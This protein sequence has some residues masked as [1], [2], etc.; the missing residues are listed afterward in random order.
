MLNKFKSIFAPKNPKKQNLKYSPY[1]RKSPR[2]INKEKVK[3]NLDIANESESTIVEAGHENLEINKGN[4]VSNES[5]INE[6]EE[7]NTQKESPKKIVKNAQIQNSKNESE[8]SINNNDEKGEKGEKEEKKDSDDIDITNNKNKRIKLNTFHYYGTGYSRNSN[9]YMP[10]R[11][12]QTK[13][14]SVLCYKKKLANVPNKTP[15]NENKTLIPEI[16]QTAKLILDVVEKEEKKYKKS[17]KMKKL[18]KKSSSLMSIDSDKTLDNKEVKSKLQEDKK[19]KKIPSVNI[20]DP[21]TS[22]LQFNFI[23]KSSSYATHPNIVELTKTLSSESFKLPIFTFERKNSNYS[24]NG[25]LEESEKSK[26]TNNKSEKDSLMAK[27]LSTG[28]NWAAAGMAKPTLAADEWKCSVCDAKNKSTDDKCVCC[29]EPNPNKKDS[30]K[31]KE[32]PKFTFG[33]S[34]GSGITFGKPATSTETK[35]TF[36][37]GK[38]TD[39]TEPKTA[40][41]IESKDT[42]PV[43]TGFNW[44]AAGMAKPTLAAD[45]WKCSVCDAKNKSTDDKCVCCEEPNPNKKDS[46]KPKEAP[47]FTFGGS[48]GS[49]ITF[50]KPA[51]STE[52]KSTFTFG[53]ST[54]TTESKT[55]ETI[56]SKDTKPVSTGFN[57]AAAGMAK[58]TLAADEWKCSVCDAKN[59]STDDKCVC[60]EEPNPNK[61][62]SNKPKEAPKFTFG[63]SS[64]SGITF[65]KP[66]TST[67]TKS[68]FTFGKS[69]DTTESKTAETIESK[70]TKPVSTGFNW[71]AAGMAKP[72][73]AA[74]EWK[75][76]VCDAKN[77][78]TDDKCVCCE[79]PNPNKKDSDKPKEAPK[80]TFGG[81][82][83][84]GITFGKPATSTETKSTFTFG[85][86][87]DTTE[88][89]TAETIESKDTKPVSTGFNWAAAGMAKPS[90]AADEW[91]CSVCDAKNKST[92]DKCVCCEEPNPNKN[93][94][95]KPKEA[96]KFTFGS[97]SSSLNKPIATFGS[98]SN[99]VTFGSSGSTTTSTAF[100][101]GKPFGS[102]TSS[103]TVTFGS[104]STT[105]SV[106]KSV[107]F[108][109]NTT[110]TNLNTKTTT[111]FSFS[112]SNTITTANSF[113]SSTTTSTSTNLFPAISF[114]KTNNN[115]VNNND[116]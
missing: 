1:E 20:F 99:T 89:K 31:L 41:T 36:T 94:S 8:I 85:K 59:K 82:S 109:F 77:K 4:L 88:S 66:T 13:K 44:A 93:D 18:E 32:A 107:G 50:G 29:E 60:C 6:K 101:F 76:S 80:F 52:T 115:D 26:D 23:R 11:K 110:S 95:D 78:S 25:S 38:S 35:S 106:P 92:D 73:L 48:S 12:L 10:A 91:K 63:G 54:D 56:E 33:G 15:K 58:P 42:K 22:D 98:N 62:D 112:T 100:G 57:W 7:G 49:G 83:G 116:N 51:T 69:T 65:G 90:L 64:G 45:E 81:S 87:T 30:N 102:N 105:S 96:P 61:K 46:D 79:E 97:N 37:F 113:S 17:I 70:D 114:G 19:I 84:S 86:S 68:T 9:P 43:S 40:E 21:E 47:K 74:D 27:P 103:N 55:V 53:K 24:F 71:A 67:E 28:F 16:S 108:S 39:T 5:N 72:T 14:S 34:S 75:C 111:G 3:E 104:T 2:I